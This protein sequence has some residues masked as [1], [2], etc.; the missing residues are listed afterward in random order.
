MVE[1][2]S[3]SVAGDF[4]FLAGGESME[5][6]YSL[7]TGTP[8]RRR[9]L[10]FGHGKLCCKVSGSCLKT[11]KRFLLTNI[12]CSVVVLVLAVSVSVALGLYAMLAVKP[13]PVIDYSLKAFTIP[14]HEVTRHQEAFEVAVEDNRN[15]NTNPHR[16]RRSV[17]ALRRQKRYTQTQCVQCHRRH[18]VILVYLAV[19]GSDH[20]IFT[21]ER[22]AAIHR[23]ES[24]VEE[25]PGFSQFC[26]KNYSPTANELQRC[27]ALDSL[28]SKYFY[29]PFSGP[30]QPDGDD[31]KLVSDFDGTVRS[32]LS[33][34]FGFLYTD[35]HANKTF[36]ES[37][38]LK[39]EVSFGMP[40]PGM[41][42]CLLQLLG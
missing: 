29:P 36:F 10:T 35:G 16:P 5:E 15:W 26:L 3:L 6:M 11:T 28:V 25:M 27:D 41:V 37:T 8:F 32:V 12:A 22:I 19:G 20:N 40:L 21:R 39:S 1:N 18:K 9:F 17:T 2:H 31:V 23:I 24:H 13:Q 34:A 7:Y 42:T 33:S 14:N 4:G 38:F 30:Q